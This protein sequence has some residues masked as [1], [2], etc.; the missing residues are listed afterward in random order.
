MC[1]FFSTGTFIFLLICIY[2]SILVCNLCE[3]DFLQILLIAIN[4][5]QFKKV[6]DI[7]IYKK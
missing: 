6:K 5:C 1:V 3:Y 2:S 4:I 7:K